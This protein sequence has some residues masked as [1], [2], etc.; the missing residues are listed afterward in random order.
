MQHDTYL[1]TGGTGFIGQQLC[2]QLAD[3]GAHLTVLS[4]RGD[5]VK[6]RLPAGTRVIRDLSELSADDRFDV[7][8]NLAGESI[9]GSR[10]T[11]RR[12][13]VLEQSRIALT[14]ALVSWMESANTRPAVFISASAIGFYGDQ[15]DAIVTEESTPVPDYAHELCRRWEAA[16]LKAEALGV[17]TAIVRIGLVIGE[18]G[19]FLKQMALP[20]W[21]GAGGP[22]GSGRQWMS[23]IHRDDLIALLR[24]VIG[25]DDAHGIFNGTAPNPVTNREFSQTLGRVIRRPSLL[26]AP[27][28]AF[29]LAFGEMAELLLTGQRVLPAKATEIGFSFHY[30]RLEQALEQVYRG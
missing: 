10:W 29:R 4:R 5:S 12:K 2:K 7:V 18:D 17:R 16:A 14:D 22:I 6:K 30:S 28:F 21:F 1:I 19:G 24:F 11:D 8:I 15:H 25:S 13:A 20:F 27:A 26:P 3:D 9:A 23:W